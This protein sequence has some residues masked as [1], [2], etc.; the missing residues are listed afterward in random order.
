VN[1]LNI[2]VF[3][4]LRHFK[5]IYSLHE[6]SEHVVKNAAVLEVSEFG[7]GV[8]AH[9]NLELLAA[10]GGHVEGLAHLEVAA[11]GWDVEVLLTGEAK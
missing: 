1:L 4:I 6:F 7:L 3:K 10:V 9:L 11:V 2:I 5:H 8:D